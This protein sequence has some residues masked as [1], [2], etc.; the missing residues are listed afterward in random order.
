MSCCSAAGAATGA[1]RKRADSSAARHALIAT[2][3]SASGAP[4]GGGPQAYPGVRA[5]VNSQPGGHFPGKR[6]GGLQSRHGRAAHGGPRVPMAKQHRRQ[7]ARR[8]RRLPVLP[9]GGLHGGGAAAG[10]P[11]RGRPLPRRCSRC[12]SRSATR[13]AG[14]GCGRSPASP[15]CRPS[16]PTRPSACAGAPCCSRTSWPG[17]RSSAG[18]WPG[19]SGASCCRF[20]AAASLWHHSLR[21]IFGTTVIAGGI[22]TAFVFFVERARV[23]AASCRPSSRPAT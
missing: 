22:T 21:Q 3:P 10:P 13:S 14:R 20:S 9:G 15:S 1:S 11:L 4:S 17:S 6:S 16:R 18:R 5:A 23:A 8:H 19:S 2:S 12:W 7:P